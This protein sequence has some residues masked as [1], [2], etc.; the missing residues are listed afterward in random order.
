MN[1]QPNSRLCFA[2]GLENPVGLHLHF[3]DNGQDE[4][5]ADFTVAPDHQGYPGVVHGGVVAAILDEIGGRTVMIGNHLRFFMTAKLEIRYRQPVPV[6]TPL[7]AVGRI[8]KLK[9]RLA[10]AHAEIQSAEGDVL[11]EAELVLSNVPEGV[12]TPSQADRLGWRVYE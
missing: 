2:C 11:A 9:E 8:V 4:V 3:Y 1:R 10:T 5:M 6:G 7:R 12:F